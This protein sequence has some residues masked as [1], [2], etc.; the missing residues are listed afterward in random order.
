MSDCNANKSRLSAS[1]KIYIYMGKNKTIFIDLHRELFMFFFSLRF[2]FFYLLCSA[3][4]AI[5]EITKI[6]CTI[7]I[8]QSQYLPVVSDNFVS[9]LADLAEFYFS[10]IR[11]NCS[12]WKK[13][14]QSTVQAQSVIVSLLFVCFCFT[15]KITL[16]DCFLFH[17]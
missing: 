1:W 10:N 16:S 5:V 13:K 8:V 11:N 6:N 4:D 9:I 2:F 14:Q 12:K 3:W 15:P 7:F 17:C